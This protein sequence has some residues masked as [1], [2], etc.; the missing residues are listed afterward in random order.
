MLLFPTL[1][2][3]TQIL[4]NYHLM[5]CVCFWRCT[6]AFM[7]PTMALLDLVSDKLQP[8]FIQVKEGQKRQSMSLKGSGLLNA[9]VNQALT[10]K[11]R[12]QGSGD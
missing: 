10:L 1:G 2:S 9:H 4:G 7:V 8:A 12:R 6:W 5:Q 3:G 11:Q